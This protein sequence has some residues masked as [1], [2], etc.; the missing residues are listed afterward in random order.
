MPTERPVGEIP[1]ICYMALHR[2]N[3]L[4]R[5]YNF[6]TLSNYIHENERKVFK[7]VH[8]LNP[9]TTPSCLMSGGGP[10]SFAGPSPSYADLSEV[11]LPSVVKTCHRCSGHCSPLS[12]AESS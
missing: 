10:R 3:I 9:T 8:E 4:I 6:H 11:H 1:A 7:L 12:L 5:Q 2:H